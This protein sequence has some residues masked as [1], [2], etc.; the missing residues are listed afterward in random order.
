[1]PEAKQEPAQSATA[2]R[3][4]KD[5]TFHVFREVEGHWHQLTKSAISASSRKDAIAKA[6]EKLEDKSGRFWA[7]IEREFKPLSLKVETEVKHIFV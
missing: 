7:V 1:V 2:A 3:P 6:V 5:A 4:K